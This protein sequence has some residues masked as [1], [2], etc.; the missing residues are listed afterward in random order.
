MSENT[1]AE[2]ELSTAESSARM[3]ART[4]LD[5]LD[6]TFRNG[7]PY[8]TFDADLPTLGYFVDELYERSN[9]FIVQ[10]RL[11]GL[12]DVMTYRDDDGVERE[13]R[14]VDVLVAP[15]SITAGGVTSIFERLQLCSDP[16]LN[17]LFAKIRNA[18]PEVLSQAGIL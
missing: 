3:R 1:S 2:G 14:T 12:E 6:E 9:D 7:T 10:V 8:V 17:A 4:A 13:P 18:R 11:A 15:T 5:W 16:D